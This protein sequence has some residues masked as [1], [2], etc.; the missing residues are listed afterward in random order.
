MRFCVWQLDFIGGNEGMLGDSELGQ[1][2]EEGILD[3]CQ[4]QTRGRSGL[5][6]N[7]TTPL[8]ATVLQK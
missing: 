5:Y 3:S 2:D 6:V 8:P 4:V 7:F 1:V